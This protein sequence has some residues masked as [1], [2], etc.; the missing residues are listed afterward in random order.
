MEEIKEGQIHGIIEPVEIDHEM[1]SAYIDYSMSVIV[2]RALPDARD[3]LKPVQ[4]RVL[5]GMDG[6]GLGYSGQTR[7]CAKIVGE[8]LGKYHPHGDSSVYDALA[9]LA[10]DWNQ[11]YPLVFGQGNFGSMDGDPVAAMRY[12]EAKLQK[13]AVDVIAD[14]DKDT[15]DMTNNFDDTELEP[16]VLPTR[17]PLLLLNGS[18]G[19]AVGMATNMAP[20]NLG[21]CCDAI[22]AYIDNPDIDVEGLMEHIK[23]PDFPTGGIIQGRQGIIDAYTTGRGKVVVRAKTEIEVAENGR[24]TIVVTEIP[25][26]VNKREMIERIGQMVE[27]KKLDG[28]TYVND[29]TSREGVRVVLRLRQG[30]N[31]NVMLNTLFKY[32]ALQSSFAINNVAL[33]N[34]RPRTLSLKDI[35]A[36][37]VDFRHE[38]VVRRTKFELDKAMKRAHILEGLLKAID[39]IDE[40]IQ[41]IKASKSVDEAKAQLVATFGFT[42]IQAQAIVEMRLRQLTGLEKEKLQAEFEELQKFIARCNQI[43]SSVDEQL[44]VVKAETMELKAKYAD[45][46]RSEIVYSS[47]EFNPEDFY[48]DDDVVITISHLGYIKRTALTEFRTQSRGGV[49]KKASA[50]RDEDFIEHIYVANMHSTMLFFTEKGMCY[51]LKVYEIPEGSRTSKGRAVQ[52]ILSIDPDDSI[53]TYLNAKSI[54]KPEYTENHYVVLVTKNGIIKRTKLTEFANKRSKNKGIIAIQFKEGDALL[55]A[56]LTDGCAQVMIAAKNGRCVR[57]D[58][59]DARELGRS[60][61]GVRA[62]TIDE[63]DEV[64]GMISYNPESED[65]KGSTILVVSENGFGKRSDPEEYRTTNRG[66]KGVKTLEITDKTGKLIAIKSVKED[67]DLMIINH[68]GMTIRMAVNDIRVCGRATQGVKLISLRDGDSIA[69]VSV[70]AG[71]EE[72]EEAQVEGATEAP[73]ET[74]SAE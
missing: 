25:Y 12:T 67:N 20:H 8:V 55:D 49:G 26:M 65:D 56:I 40:I 61:M 70:V 23:G 73:A 51:R 53:K 7:K 2:S 36:N 50:T 69:A 24:E 42:E 4:R 60:S 16:T 52:N 66:A 41:I 35:I 64:I 11:R 27:E 22:C 1:R 62:I 68:S 37:F 14:I 74:P 33:V 72:Q 59:N 63:D 17:A 19:I 21:E 30:T 44:A 18:S 45:P 38:V 46:R 6:L 29:E 58:E 43:L 48:A 34:G 13:L 15:V 57:F 54:E 9:R 32:T 47:E 28:I 5:F 3:G 39:V 10:Q 31:S 71:S